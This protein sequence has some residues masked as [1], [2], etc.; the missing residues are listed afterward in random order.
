ML[1]PGSPLARRWA[2]L[3]FVV[4]SMCVLLGPRP[5]ASGGTR[6]LGKQGSSLELR[7]TGVRV[8]AV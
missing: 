8:S 2:D 6:Q 3:Y 5:H 7:E 1:G 4:W